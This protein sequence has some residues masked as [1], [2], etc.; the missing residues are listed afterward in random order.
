M[1]VFFPSGSLFVHRVPLHML[2]QLFL[3]FHWMM[4]SQGLL[5]PDQPDAAPPLQL[6]VSIVLSIWW[7]PNVTSPNQGLSKNYLWM[8]RNVNIKN[9]NEYYICII[10]LFFNI[11]LLVYLYVCAWCSRASWSLFIYKP[12]R[13]KNETKNKRKIL[14]LFLRILCKY[15]CL[16]K[17]LIFVVCWVFICP[18]E[19]MK[20]ITSVLMMLVLYHRPS[21]LR[22]LD[23]PLYFGWEVLQ[24]GLKED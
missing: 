4:L 9:N 22:A 8:V 14:I 11:W 6:A 19:V 2:Q 5:C 17:R 24:V 18:L 12:K 23:A 15:C 1:H 13:Q 20:M 21:W 7:K 3:L 16:K 10:D